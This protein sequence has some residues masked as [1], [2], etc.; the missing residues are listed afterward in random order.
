M[1]SSGKQRVPIARA[2]FAKDAVS[3]FGIEMREGYPAR[4]G[5]KRA[6]DDAVVDQSVVHDHVVAAKQLPDHSDVGRM[7]ADEGD[8]IF[9]AVQVCQL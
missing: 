2:C 6:L 7:A 8:A 4:A 5:Q 9:G 3:G 1:T